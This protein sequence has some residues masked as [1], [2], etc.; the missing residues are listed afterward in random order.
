M[1]DLMQELITRFAAPAAL[2]AVSFLAG[3]P[4]Q[5]AQTVPAAPQ[6]FVVLQSQGLTVPFES[7]TGEQA[8][9][10][11]SGNGS[12]ATMRCQTPP[13]TAKASYHYVA[14]LV[15]DQQGMA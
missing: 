3:C 14:I 6:Q 10:S 15:V 7:L 9:C 2:A 11:I 8:H 12:F 5:G 1:G 4:M 13:A